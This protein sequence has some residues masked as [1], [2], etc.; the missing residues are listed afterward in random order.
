MQAPIHQEKADGL[1]V[2][3]GMNSD[4]SVT[5]DSINKFVCSPDNS[6]F[7]VNADKF[8]ELKAKLG[9][10]LWPLSNQLHEILIRLFI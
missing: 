7:L 5:D 9:D 10:E 6:C 4:L 3:Q 1:L 8:C 2:S